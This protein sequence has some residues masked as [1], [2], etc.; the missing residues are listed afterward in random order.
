[1]SDLTRTSIETND[2]NREPT[3]QEL[4]EVPEMTQAEITEVTKSSEYR[5][6]KLVQK[7]VV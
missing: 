2:L 1:M 6:S 4:A 7:L 5:N 3:A